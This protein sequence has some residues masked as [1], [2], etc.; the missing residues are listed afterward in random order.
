MY[1]SYSNFVVSAIINSYDSHIIL[2]DGYDIRM[3]LAEY[4]YEIRRMLEVFGGE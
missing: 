2:L 1:T 4:L 3:N